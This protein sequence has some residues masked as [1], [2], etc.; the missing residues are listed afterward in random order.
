MKAVLFFR[1]GLQLLALFTIVFILSSCSNFQTKKVFQ[2]IY[3]GE[4]ESKGIKITYPFNTTI[5]PPEIFSPNFEWNDSI[6]GSKEWTVFISDTSGNIIISS[7]STENKWKPEQT[8]WEQLKINSSSKYYQ[9]TV[10]A[11][12]AKDDFY[13]SGRT[14]FSISEDSVNADIFYRAV[15]LPFSYAVKNVHTIEWYLGSIDGRKPRKMLDNLP[16][17][18]NCHSFARDQALLAMDVDYGN[19]KGSYVIAELE[20]TCKLK[21][22]KIIS[23]SDYKRED[24]EPTFGLLSQIS[25][26]GNHV[27]S[28]VKDLSIFVAVD[29]NLAYSQLF[30]PIKGVVG[31]YDR[32]AKTF[33]VL[34]GASDPK[35]V[36]SNATWSPDGKKV[37]FAR[38][39]AYINEKVRAAGTALLSLD[40]VNEF[41]TG[42]KE[43]KYDLYTVDFN[44]GKGGESVP[45]EGASQN[46][47]SNFFPKFS[48]DGKWIVFCQA[49]NF[50]L[51]QPDSRLY[52]MPA[53]G[54]E[55]RLMNCNMNQMNSWHSWSPNGRWLVFSSK[56]RGLYTQLYLTHID[57][58]GIDSPPVLLENLIFDKRAV[59]IPE[60]YPFDGDQLKTIIDDFSNTADYY[61]RGAFDKMSNQCFR[62]AMDDLNMAIHLDSNNAEAYFNRIMLNSLLMQSNSYQDLAD[63][64]KA[65]QLVLDSLA[66][67]PND[68]GFLTLKI[69]LLSNMGREDEALKEAKKALIQYPD[70]YKLYELL[71]SIYRKENQ[72]ENAINCYHKMIRLYPKKEYALNKLIAGAY[73]NLNQNEKVIQIVNKYIKDKGN[74]EDL[75]FLRAQAQLN[76]KKHDL[77]LKDINQYLETDPLNYKFNDLLAQYYL[78]QGSKQLYLAQSRKN[79]EILNNLYNKN[80]EDIEII[81]KIASDYMTL[82]DYK[83]AE[84]QYDLVL[85]S[86]PYNYESLKEKAVINLNLQQWNRAISIYDQL[87]SSYPPE[88]G[89]CNNKA[90]AY[91]QTGNFSK[92]LEYFNETL[93]INPDNKDALF[94]RN[95]LLQERFN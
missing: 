9:F 43:F 14:Q 44:N 66:V 12:R 80:P 11:N 37:I 56:N 63:K 79:L 17:C 34:K 76:L 71:G 27:L 58:N 93:E 70:Y 8:D 23:W 78:S 64:K 67:E 21:P 13:A 15:T 75:L 30:F 41:T 32:K 51:L 59:N 90:I 46:G 42:G 82:K 40:D 48:P 5:F 55:P 25:P 87:E 89:F 18:G 45:L 10:I 1:S 4:I 62:R 6:S 69:S 85:R 47:K 29:D 39:D 50:M 84:K 33:D 31:I 95:K 91:I 7:K 86:F 92:A 22:D 73:L 19:D 35:F 57:E 26:D 53:G 24:D 81:F 94:N 54:G 72:Y 88:E 49:E 28:T 52:I 60:F 36:Q 16:V 77:A 20:D 74:N 61:N 68:K 3:D 83:N 65:M 38:T 2:S